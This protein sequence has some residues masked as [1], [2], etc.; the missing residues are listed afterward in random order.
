[1]QKIIEGLRE[2]RTKTE[3]LLLRN[4]LD[5]K[6]LEHN[7]KEKLFKEKEDALSKESY[8][9][10]KSIEFHSQ[11]YASFYNTRLEKDKSILTLSVAGLGFLIT[12]TNFAYSLGYIEIAIF[13]LSACC[14]LA[15]IYHVISIF[16]KNAIYIIA[17]TTN[18]DETVGKLENTLAS[19]D[20]WAIRLFYLGIVTSFILGLSTAINAQI[21]GVNT[22]SNDN[23]KNENTQLE[24]NESF[25]SASLMKKSFSGISA[26]K[27]KPLNSDKPQ[28]NQNK[29]NGGS[30]DKQ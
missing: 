20:R 22:M 14:Y 15:C 9:T 19:H 17:L 30:N 7:K 25:N 1:L 28:N 27:P 18:D 4:E 2:A 29:S 23:K 12:F 24:I 8:E 5:K 26:A 3:L 16:D 6:L 21:K 11:A 10:S 13:L